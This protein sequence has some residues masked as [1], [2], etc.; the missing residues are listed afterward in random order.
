[1][2]NPFFQRFDGADCIH[3]SLVVTLFDIKN[4]IYINYIAFILILVVWFQPNRGS[5]RKARAALLLEW[6][7]FRTLLPVSLDRTALAALQD[8][9]ALASLT[10]LLLSDGG[11][12]PLNPSPWI[13]KLNPQL[14]LLGVAAGNP[15]NLPDAETLAALQ[16]YTLL[17]TDR[18]GWIE[19]ATDGEQL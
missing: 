10:A 7:N 13:V 15:R 6:S 3:L 16:G 17:R 1:L 5:D 14:V 8:N 4:Y 19:L 9:P 12:A 11:Y 2:S 18:N